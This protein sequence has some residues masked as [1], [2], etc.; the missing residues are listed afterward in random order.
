MSPTK[1]VTVTPEA[2]PNPNTYKFN[3]NRILIEAGSVDFTNAA[4]AAGSPIGEAI[5]KIENVESV[6]VGKDFIT[7]TKMPCVGWLKLLE[8]I[9]KAVES[10][11]NAQ[12]PLFAQ[13]TAPIGSKGTD[14]SKKEIVR[15]ICEVLDSEIRPALAMDG[16]DVTFVDYDNGIVKLHLQGSCRHCPSAVMTLK[17]GVEAR[18]KSVIPQIQEVVAV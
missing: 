14:S 2:T 16:G 7:V 4:A 3:V 1:T 15:K 6:M 5:F 13:R 8:P 9:R 10:V 12:M 17:M 11:L 18:L